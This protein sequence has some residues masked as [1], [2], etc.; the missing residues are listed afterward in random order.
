MPGLVIKELDNKAE[1]RVDTKAVKEI[2]ESSK[3]TVRRV[4]P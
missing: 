4:R 1:A 3:K 2:G